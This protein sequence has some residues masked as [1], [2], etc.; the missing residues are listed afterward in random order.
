MYENGLGIDKDLM[1]AY[2]LYEAAA[3]EG[4]AIAYE[5]LCIYIY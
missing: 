1:K 2:A 4:Y 5:N 3:Y